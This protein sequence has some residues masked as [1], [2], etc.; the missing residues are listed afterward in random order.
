[1]SADVVARL[2]PKLPSD[3]PLRCRCGHVRGVEIRV[4]P[5]S[6]LRLVCYCKD[7]Q[8]FARFLG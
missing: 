2:A 4:S 6:G 7:C 5:S 8:A 3:V 1:M